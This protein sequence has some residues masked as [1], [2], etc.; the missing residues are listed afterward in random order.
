[1]QSFTS[2]AIGELG[3]INGPRCCKR[4]AMIAF[5]NGVDYVNAHYDVTLQYEQMKCEF[6]E[7]NEQCIK[8]R[9]PFYAH[10]FQQEY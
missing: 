3:I 7:L 10:S 6:T 2:K 9:C 1:M 5:K 4:D 8:D